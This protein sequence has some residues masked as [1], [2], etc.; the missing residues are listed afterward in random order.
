MQGKNWWQDPMYAGIFKDQ[1]TATIEPTGAGE[2]GKIQPLN[3]VGMLNTTQGPKMLHEGELQITNPDGSF[4]V[5]PS[6]M[7]PQSILRAMEQKSKMGGFASG[8]SGQLVEEPKYVEQP[9][10]QTNLGAIAPPSNTQ[11][12]SLPNPVTQKTPQP[13]GV[14]PPITPAVRGDQDVAT[15][16]IRDYATGKGPYLQSLLN[17]AL[18]KQGA[19]GAAGT[20]AMKQ[21]LAMAG[22]GQDALQTATAVRQRDVESQNAQLEADIANQAMEKQLGAAGTLSNIATAKEQTAYERQRYAEE[23]DYERQKYENET[24]YNR[25]LTAATTA[26]NAGDYENAAVLFKQA[27]PNSNVDFSKIKT[28]AEQQAFGDAVSNIQTWA[29]T[30]DMSF[31][32]L[33][34]ILEKA[35]I[36]KSGVTKEQARSMVQDIRNQT[37]PITAA[38]ATFSDKNIKTLWPDLDEKQYPTLRNELVQLA[39]LGGAS[40]DGTID[41]SKISTT[42]MPTLSKLLGIETETPE[43]LFS[44]YKLVTADKT[45][46]VYTF[47]DKNGNLFNFN[48][49]QVSSNQALSSISKGA[50]QAPTEAWADKGMIY[51]SDKD[52]V[53]ADQP[54]MFAAAGGVWTGKGKQTFLKEGEK[55]TLTQSFGVQDTNLSIPA[56]NYTAVSTTIK[57]G[58]Q[59]DKRTLLQSEDGKRFYPTDHYN[60]DNKQVEMLGYIWVEEGGYYLK[61][62]PKKG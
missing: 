44:G 28:Q 38:A 49:E 17:T 42:S 26:F 31:E 18:T 7:L 45:N 62:R 24:N 10:Q 8:G 48:G 57:R 33:D 9:K 25:N 16:V 41:T 56:G 19:A 3:P 40:K 20:A 4:A 14:L 60:V 58:T 46:D 2:D 39:V 52:N 15:D 1:Q 36:Y 32:E 35:G 47:A 29:T 27:F 30:S 61:A 51:G 59:T 54:N 11:I 21:E 23:R 34:P 12:Q 53:Y 6:T 43:E 22:A 50:G 37:N 5:I 55:V 13:A